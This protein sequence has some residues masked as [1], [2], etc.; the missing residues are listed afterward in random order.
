MQLITQYLVLALM[1]FCLASAA[2]SVVE[3][4]VQHQLQLINFGMGQ[5]ETK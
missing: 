1:G 4:G 5:V 3:G 2:L